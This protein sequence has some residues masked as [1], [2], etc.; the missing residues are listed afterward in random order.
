M[1]VINI[2]SNPLCGSSDSAVCGSSD[3]DVIDSLCQPPEVCANAEDNKREHLLKHT[4]DSNATFF[5]KTIQRDKDLFIA[6]LFMV[7]LMHVPYLKFTTYPFLIFS[8]WVHE[9]CHGMAA[10][11]VGGSVQKLYV[12]KDGSGLAYT[13][14]SGESWKRVFVASAGYIGTAVSGALLLLFRRTRRGPTVG[15]MGM[16][17]AMLRSCVLYVRN[18]FGIVAIFLMGSI[19]LV[20]GWKLP[21][22]GVT[23]LYCFLAATCSFNALDSIK[24]LLDMQDGEAYVNGQKSSTD[25]HTV[26][27]LIGMS[28]GFWA[29]LWLLFGLIMSA[30]GLLFPFDGSTIRK[31]RKEQHYTE[32]TFSPQHQQEHMPTY[33]FNPQYQPQQNIPVV[34]ATLY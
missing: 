28:S 27:D 20:C 17:C 2:A 19:T 5:E 34:H 14:T 25:A 6:I 11:V 7:F 31:N 21:A 16:G 15:L 10:I 9:M 29:M 22:Q 32:H 30:I 4:T 24:D 12:Y 13:G 33:P 8:T 18:T 26:A 3:Q 23:Y 1:A